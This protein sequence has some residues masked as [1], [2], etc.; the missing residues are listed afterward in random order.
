MYRIVFGSEVVGNLAGA[1]RRV[2]IHDEQINRRWQGQKPFRERRKVFPLIISRYYDQSAVQ[3]WLLDKPV[4]LG[5]QVENWSPRQ[6]SSDGGRSA[7]FMPLQRAKSRPLASL[8]GGPDKSG[9]SVAPFLVGGISC[10][11]KATLVNGRS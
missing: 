8:A 9:A 4:D 5:K 1:I 10:F 11:R 3:D 7:A 6:A 2:V